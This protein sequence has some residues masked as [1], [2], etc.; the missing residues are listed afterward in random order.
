[1]NETAIEEAGRILGVRAAVV[2][3]APGKIAVSSLADG[4]LS[5]LFEQLYG[6]AGE[7]GTAMG[8]GRV[9]SVVARTEDDED[10]CLF[11]SGDQALGVVSSAS[12]SPSDVGKDVRALKVWS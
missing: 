4:E 9:G 10:L 8:L 7:I 3:E 5:G 12:R 11:L 6:I 1:M 2:V